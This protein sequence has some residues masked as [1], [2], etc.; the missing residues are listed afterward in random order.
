M[1]GALRRGI[2]ASKKTRRGVS[3]QAPEVRHWFE[4]A[5]TFAKRLLKSAERKEAPAE[6]QKPTTVVGFSVRGK[7]RP[8]PRATDH[9]WS[10]VKEKL[11]E[12]T[13][14]DTTPTMARPTLAD[15]DAARA[16]SVRSHL[17]DDAAAAAG[18]GD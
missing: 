3:A 4:E 12:M 10:S 5:A 13:A 9:R 14:H 7:L 6:A 11:A 8:R 15:A 16:I 17:A 2:R 1:R 18:G